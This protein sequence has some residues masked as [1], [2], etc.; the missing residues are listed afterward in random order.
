[1]SRKTGSFLLELLCL[2]SFVAAARG[3][4]ESLYKTR[5]NGMDLWFDRQTGSLEYLSSPAT[6]VL[7]EG[8]RERS[9]LLDVAYPI[10]EFTPL[11]LAS[12]FSRAQVLQE[13][14]TVTI[15]WEV[16]GPSRGNFPLPEGRVSA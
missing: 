2:T 14:N 16:L 9:G 7:L 13:G 11:R 6:G 5:L 1:V 4:E 3:A 12:R 8:T 10:K 15:Q